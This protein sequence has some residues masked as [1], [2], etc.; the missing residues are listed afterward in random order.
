MLNKLTITAILT[1]L[2]LPGSTPVYSA[3]EGQILG[4]SLSSPVKIEVFSDFQCP[5]CRDFYL[6]T[7]RQVLQN[8]SRNNKVG[9]IYHE[10]QIIA[11][12]KYSIIAARYAEAASRMG[13]QNLLRVYDALYA[14]QVKWG[15]NG[16]VEATLA[17]ALSSQDFQTIKRIVKDPSIDQAIKRDADLAHKQNIRSTPT[18]IL[19]YSGKQEKVENAITYNLM[20]QAIDSKLK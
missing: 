18:I 11:G 16:N 5:S 4:G 13:L 6:G 8:Y 9:V 12:H 2:V 10:L 20:K 19:H 3:N 1:L 7:I 14:D 17:K 15:Q